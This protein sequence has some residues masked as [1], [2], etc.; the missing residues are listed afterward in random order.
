MPTIHVVGEI[1]GASGLGSAEESSV[2]ASVLDRLALHPASERSFFCRWRLL[3]STCWEL[4]EGQ[5]DGQTQSHATGSDLPVMKAGKQADQLLDL[6]W[7]HPIDLHLAT[8]EPLSGWPQLEFQVCDSQGI[9][10]EAEYSFRPSD[11]WPDMEPRLLPPRTLVYACLLSMRV[12]FFLH[13]P[14][15]SLGNRRLGPIVHSHDQSGAR[16][17][18]SHHQAEIKDMARAPG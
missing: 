4:L 8:P 12:A 17:G 2:V 14:C 1:L 13:S 15:S 9:A 7:A 11:L 3:S 5:A 6:I 16:A 10:L 18:S